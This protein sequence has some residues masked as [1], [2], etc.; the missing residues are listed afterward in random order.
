M[1]SLRQWPDF[2]G[3]LLFKLVISILLF[4]VGYILKVHLFISN[5]IIFGGVAVLLDFLLDV[6]VKVIGRLKQFKFVQKVS[7]FKLGKFELS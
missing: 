3:K 7:E 2:K 1:L 5:L 4:V 6:L